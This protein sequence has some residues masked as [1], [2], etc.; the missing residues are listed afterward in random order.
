[1]ERD[2]GVK[3]SSNLKWEEHVLT[4][5]SKANSIL[6][7]L[8]RTFV[9]IDPMSFRVLYTSLVRPHLEFAVPVWSPHQKSDIKTLEKVQR[10][11]LKWLNFG[12]KL[13]YEEK[14]LNVELLSLETRRVR[15]DLIQMYKL[16]HK[17][18]K[19]SI[20]E[21]DFQKRTNTRRHD[22]RYTREDVKISHRVN[23][24]PNR[25]ANEWNALPV[26]VVTAPSINCFKARL[27]THKGW[28]NLS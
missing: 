2:L 27:D 4:C 19:A 16:I 13:G 22:L 6:G 3:F 5:A 1:M 20:T 11:A 17:L 15:G 8:K 12:M 14:L 21:I 7:R 26:K 28:N 23:F 24:L 10:R 9:S 25:I 18:D